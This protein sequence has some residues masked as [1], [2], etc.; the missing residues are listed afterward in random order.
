MVRWRINNSIPPY[1]YFFNTADADVINY[2]KVFTF[3]SKEE[4]NE[5]ERETLDNPGERK[6]Q[7]V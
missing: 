3:L 6:A 2:L 5:L 4:I 1:Q 7:N